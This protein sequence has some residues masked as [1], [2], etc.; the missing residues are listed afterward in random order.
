MD[1][2]L[3]FDVA[4]AFSV[5]GQV[6]LV[7]GATGFIGGVIAEAF[8]SNGARV[9]LTDRDGARLEEQVARLRRQGRDV[10]SVT[11]DLSDPAT[12]EALV[13]AALAQAGRLD[14][15]INCAGIPASPPMDLETVEGAD[16]LMDVNVRAIWL[17]VRAASGPMRRQGAGQIVNIASI[18]GHHAVFPCP[19][20]A[21]SKA[22]VLMLTRELSIELAALGIRINSVSPGL[23]AHLDADDAWVDR[24][25][26][27]PYRS[28]FAARWREHRRR[29]V[30][31]E[32]PL[33]RAG[34]PI[35]V[36]MACLYLCSPAARFITGADLL[37][38]GGRLQEM[39]WAEK[40]F[41]TRRQ[42]NEGV[43]LYSELRALPEDA[44]LRKPRWLTAVKV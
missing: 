11:G 32:Q 1:S 40:R 35:D 3:S 19:V 12:P 10:L 21:A 34:Q 15:V 43:A 31:L 4:A 44:W 28:Q 33:T 14:T 5:R 29:M 2:V 26:R 13:Q 7:T 38:D 6:A 22:A 36:A 17:L 25:L 42:D 9:V 30:P 18:N 39:S 41:E 24:F 20:Y 16:R 37:V 23:I 27:E 8:A